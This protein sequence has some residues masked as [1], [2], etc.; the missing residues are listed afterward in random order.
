MLLREAAVS[1]CSRCCLPRETDPNAEDE[2]SA[3]H[4]ACNVNIFAFGFSI[5]CGQD[6]ETPLHNAALQ[7]HNES[8]HLLLSAKGNPNAE[9]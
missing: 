2:V 3:S 6:K 7:G 5:L 9:N 1:Q 4:S 8:V